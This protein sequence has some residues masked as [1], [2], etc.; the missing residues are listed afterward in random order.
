V[1]L[2]TR[3]RPP[4]LPDLS[5]LNAICAAKPVLAAVGLTPTGAGAVCLKPADRRFP[6]LTAHVDVIA[7]AGR[8]DDTTDDFGHR[9]LTRRGDPEAFDD[10]VADLVAANQRVIDA[11]LG[12]ALL[13]TLLGFTAAGGPTVLVYRARRG[14][15]YPV[16]P[17]GAQIRDN[18]RELS[19]RDQ[20]GDALAIEPD[21]SKWSP[22]W[23][24]PVP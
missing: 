16:V 5:A 11:G 1:G 2:L 12:G 24:A 3:R 8:Y 18:E 4:T 20:L 6:D 13:C 7:A 21:L 22:L 17:A 23:D 10:V 14:T 9:W 15:W 19:L